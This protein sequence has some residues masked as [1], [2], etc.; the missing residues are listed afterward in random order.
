[1]SQENIDYKALQNAKLTVLMDAEKIVNVQGQE[2]HLTLDMRLAL[3]NVLK[4]MVVR[5]MRQLKALASPPKL[6]ASD[7]ADRQVDF[8]DLQ[9]VPDS[10][11]SSLKKN[12]ADYFPGDK[13]TATLADSEKALDHSRTEGSNPSKLKKS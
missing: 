11:P 8:V 9:N 12:V 5:E 4:P 3:W 13:K 2:L 6:S 7:G 1:M 10:D